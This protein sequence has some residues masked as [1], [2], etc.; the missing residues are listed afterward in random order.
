MQLELGDAQQS[1]ARLNIKALPF[2]AHIP[3]KLPVPPGAAVPLSDNDKMDANRHPNYP[4]K[5]DSFADFVAD[6]AGY[7]INVP[8]PPSLLKSRY[9]PAVALAGVAI[10]GVMAYQL[11]YAP[12][13]RIKY[14]LC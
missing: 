7:R 2:V 10:A 4:W 6:M 5:P 11:L 12:F 8:E 13:M 9:F 3:S 1:F 14:V